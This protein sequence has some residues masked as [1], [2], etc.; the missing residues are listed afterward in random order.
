[1]RARRH[2]AGWQNKT[3]PGDS[4]GAVLLL[5]EKKEKKFSVM[6]ARSIMAVL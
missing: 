5:C 6:D 3:A 4:H 1:M 2:P